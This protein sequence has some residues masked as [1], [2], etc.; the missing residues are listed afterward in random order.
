MGMQILPTSTVVCPHYRIIS[1]SPTVYMIS[2]VFM[3]SAGDL[4]LFHCIHP[5]LLMLIACTWCHA[6][7]TRSYNAVSWVYRPLYN[8]T[9]TNERSNLSHSVNKHI[10]LQEFLLT[11]RKVVKL[12]NK[13]IICNNEVDNFKRRGGG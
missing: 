11:F 12:N 7:K 8:I 6:S 13:V 4:G 2:S 10:R 9:H 3:K 1:S 5:G